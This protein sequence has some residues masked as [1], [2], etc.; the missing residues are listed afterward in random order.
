MSSFLDRG[1]TFKEAFN[2]QATRTH[3]PHEALFCFR[4]SRSLSAR[5]LSLSLCPL[6]LS[7]DAEKHRKAS[8]G[9]RTRNASLSLL[10]PSHLPFKS[11]LQPPIDVPCRSAKTSYDSDLVGE[12]QL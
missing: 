4:Q 8:Y 7:R 6:I 9:S 11:F 10:T 12:D 5:L 2:D 3:N 1:P